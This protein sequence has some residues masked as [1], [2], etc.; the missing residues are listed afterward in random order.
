M[1]RLLADQKKRSETSLEALRRE[2]ETLRTGTATPALLN[3]VRVEAYGET[4]P[5]NQVGTVAVMEGRL[6][7]ITPW[8]KTLLPAVEKAILTSDLG[9]TPNNDGQVV[10]LQIP[11]LSEERRQELA[12]V[13]SR[14]AEEA[15]VAIRNIRRDTLATME[16][17]QEAEGWSDDEVEAGKKDAQKTTD[18]CIEKVDE[19]AEAKTE[20]IMTI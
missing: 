5:L 18:E 1:D 14:K 8:D 12:K 15:K 13:V 16:K 3:N 2:F 6:L 4:L 17:R 7:V 9:L 11:P 10:R 20:E 19:I